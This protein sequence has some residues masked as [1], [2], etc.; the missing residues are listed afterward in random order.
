[1][2]TYVAI[3]ESN[4]VYVRPGPG[5][6]RSGIGGKHYSV[7]AR[8]ALDA[9]HNLAKLLMQKPKPSLKT[10]ATYLSKLWCSIPFSIGIMFNSL[11][12][13]RFVF[14]FVVKLRGTYC[15]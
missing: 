3:K 7:G 11:F 12:Q 9:A 8:A 6:I 5:G 2:C 14:I 13:L 1:M 10:I 15:I 4:A